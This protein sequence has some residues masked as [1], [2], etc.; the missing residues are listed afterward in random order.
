MT[1]PIDRLRALDDV[2]FHSG[3]SASDISR[4]EREFAIALPRGH[5]EFLRSINGVEVYAGYGRLFGMGASPGIDAAEWNREDCWKFAWAARRP[6]AWCF[7]ETVWG[8]QYA[9]TIDALRRGGE[10]PVVCFDACTMEPRTVAASFDEFL[11][12][13]FLRIATEPYDSMMREARVRF[14]ALPPQTHLVHVPSVLLGAPESI[15]RVMPMPARAAMI[16]NGDVLTQIDAAGADQVVR[17]L[18][19]YIDDRGRS[20]MRIVWG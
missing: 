11:E 2:R 20:R 6:D 3:A 12:R 13:E 17:A 19:T 14:G 4:I 15:E 8:D 9:Y 10:P 16:A 7:A 5:R 18:E 1:A